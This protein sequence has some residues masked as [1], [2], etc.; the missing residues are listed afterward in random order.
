MDL[1]LLGSVHILLDIAHNGIMII[2][3]TAAQVGD[4][5]GRGAQTG[6]RKQP[7]QKETQRRWKRVY[8]ED[9]MSS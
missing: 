4:M 7:N 1:K 2:I 5:V 9:Q 3:F 8:S 6:F